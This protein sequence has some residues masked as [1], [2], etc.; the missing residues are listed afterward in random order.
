MVKISEPEEPLRFLIL[1]G[2]MGDRPGSYQV[3]E[4]DGQDTVPGKDRPKQ[5]EHA[6]VQCEIPRPDEEPSAMAEG[7]ALIK[8]TSEELRFLIVYDNVEGGAPTIY[9][10]PRM[11]PGGGFQHALLA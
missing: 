5:R 1:A 3:Y 4:W 7:I 8:A 11:P 10:C 2:P 6:K 9:T